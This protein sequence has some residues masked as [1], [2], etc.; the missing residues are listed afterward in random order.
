MRAYFGLVILFE[1]A[2]CSRR[3]G[4]FN[5]DAACT[6]RNAYQRARIPS[7]RSMHVPKSKTRWLVKFEG[8]ASPAKHQTDASSNARHV[9]VGDVASDHVQAATYLY[10]LTTRNYPQHA[11]LHD[12]SSSLR[13]AVATFLPLPVQGTSAMATCNM[14]RW[15]AVEVH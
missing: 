8:V 3:H 14:G 6:I 1:E 12:Q 13:N 5:W 11:T 10:L 15:V 4:V 7:N 9:T 2:F